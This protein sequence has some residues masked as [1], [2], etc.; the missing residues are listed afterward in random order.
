MVRKLGASSDQAGKN[1]VSFLSY[2]LVGDLDKCLELLI[3]AD[4]LPE[5]AFFARSYLPSQVNNII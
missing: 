4:R 3:D 1:N 5:A 2:M